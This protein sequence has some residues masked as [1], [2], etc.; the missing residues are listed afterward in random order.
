MQVPLDTLQFGRLELE[1]TPTGLGQSGHLL[2]QLA[3]ASRGQQGDHPHVRSEGDG[4]SQ[5]DP[6][7]PEVVTPGQCPHPSHH[8]A[9]RHRERHLERQRPT[10]GPSPG[11]QD[12]AGQEHRG[13][14]AQDHPPRPVVPGPGDRPRHGGAEPHRGD[15]GQHRPGGR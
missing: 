1:R 11:D 9:D 6:D 10:L 12:G 3:L 15:Q 4:Q 14:E 5:V 7:R 13:H 2:P 8:Q